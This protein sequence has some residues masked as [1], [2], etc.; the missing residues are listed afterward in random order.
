MGSCRSCEISQKC[1]AQP[2]KPLLRIRIQGVKY[3]PKTAKKTRFLLL[4]LKSEL[5]KKREILK[6]PY[7]RM[8]HQV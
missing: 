3:Q 2:V 7:F 6:F 4:K 5:L 8:V 1:W